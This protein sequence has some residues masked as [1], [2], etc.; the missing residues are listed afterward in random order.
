MSNFFFLQ[1]DMKKD[2]IMRK[3]THYHHHYYHHLRLCD[4]HN[5][6]TLSMLS[7][8]ILITTIFF[9]TIYSNHFLDDKIEMQTGLSSFPKVKQMMVPEFKPNKYDFRVTASKLLNLEEN[10]ERTEHMI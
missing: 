10:T 5:S 4:K 2:F 7:N 3:G 6:S 9:F 1:L 8:W